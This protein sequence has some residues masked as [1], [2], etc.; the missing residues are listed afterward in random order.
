MSET[1]E[2]VVSM[3]K[4][5]YVIIWAVALAIGLALA[6]FFLVNPILEALAK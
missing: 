5:E 3:T 6:R 2:P 4:L 1:G